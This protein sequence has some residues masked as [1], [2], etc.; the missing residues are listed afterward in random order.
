MCPQLC[1][2]LLV[3]IWKPAPFSWAIESGGGTSIQST[4]PLR[5]AASRVVGS[6][7]GRSTSLSTLGMRFGFQYALLTSS[8]R[9]SRGTNRVTRNGPVPDGDSA[10]LRQSFP[11]LFQFAGDTIIKYRSW[12]GT[13]LDG[14]MDSN[15]TV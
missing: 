15:S 12:Y 8:S 1:G 5:S 10:Y 2:Y 3:T 14:L 7:I 13:K 6:G 4:C 9:R 11:T